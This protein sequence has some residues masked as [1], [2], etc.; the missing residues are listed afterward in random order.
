MTHVQ[1][2]TPSERRRIR[3][4]QRLEYQK[5]EQETKDVPPKKNEPSAKEKYE[6]LNAK[7]GGKKTKNCFV[8]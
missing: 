3:D 1:H 4:L 5:F 6:A 8:K 7:R 2:G